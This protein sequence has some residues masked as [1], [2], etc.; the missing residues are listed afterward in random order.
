MVCRCIN[1]QG[2]SDF[3]FICCKPSAEWYETQ[4]SK[5]LSLHHFME[6]Y[7][8]IYTVNPECDYSLYCECAVVKKKFRF[9]SLLANSISQEKCKIS[10]QACLS[11]IS[12]EFCFISSQC[13]SEGKDTPWWQSL[14]WNILMVAGTT[15]T[16]PTA[17]WRYNMQLWTIRPSSNLQYIKLQHPS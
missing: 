1:R 10:M 15:S 7:H 3:R 16:M 9:F 11:F 2:I 5:E 12:S 14:P 4:N 8:I 6:P 13:K 17:K